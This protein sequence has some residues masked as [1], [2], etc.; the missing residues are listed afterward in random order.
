MTMGSENQS[1]TSANE[2]FQMNKMTSEA[3]QACHTRIE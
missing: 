2:S 3:E 1:S